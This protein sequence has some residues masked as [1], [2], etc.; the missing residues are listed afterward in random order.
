[1]AA[2]QRG[3]STTQVLTDRGRR[4]SSPSQRSWLCSELDVFFLLL[5]LLKYFVKDDRKNDNFIV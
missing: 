2:T 1:M 4:W 5:Y 3:L